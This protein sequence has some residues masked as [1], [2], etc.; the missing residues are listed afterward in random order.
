MGEIEILRLFFPIE[1][2]P[3]LYTLLKLRICMQSLLKKK[4]TLSYCLY[5]TLEGTISFFY[6]QEKKFE[7]ESRI[8]IKTINVVCST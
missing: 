5:G 6:I 2:S 4:C 3:A 7:Q 8:G 1:E